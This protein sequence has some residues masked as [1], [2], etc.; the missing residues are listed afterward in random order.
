M[1]PKTLITEMGEK[2]DETFRALTA[3]LASIKSSRPALVQRPT[4]THNCS[5]CLYLGTRDINGKIYDF[6]KPSS[7]C[8]PLPSI[9]V[10]Y[11]NEEQNHSSYPVMCGFPVNKDITEILAAI[12]VVETAAFGGIEQGFALEDCRQDGAIKIHVSPFLTER[13]AE[14]INAL[15]IHIF[16]KYENDSLNNEMIVSVYSEISCALAYFKSINE[17]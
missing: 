10:R 16:G 14:I 4:F 5:N 7:V 9:I 17:W 2:S 11:G 12:F 1:I 3:V 13:R 15:T 6:Y 8:N